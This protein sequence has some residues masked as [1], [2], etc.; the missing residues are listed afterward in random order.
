MAR[1]VPIIQ[2]GEKDTW[3]I[4][5]VLRQLLDLFAFSARE[6]LTA[7]R[8][9]FVAT[10]GNDNSDGL[11]SATAFLTIQ[12]AIDTVAL[13][14]TG[15]SNV[16]VSVAAGTY[17][18]TA[19]IVLK[20]PLG[21][22]TCTLVGDNSNPSNVVVSNATNDCFQASGTRRW[23]IQGIKVTSAAS[24]GVLLTDGAVMVLANMDYG[25][26]AVGAVVLSGTGTS[27]TTLGVNNKW[28]GN[29]P[30]LFAVFNVAS[31]VFN[32]TFTI[33][34][35]LTTTQTIISHGNAYIQI[36]IVWLLG[37]FSVTGRRFLANFDGDIQTFGAG[38]NYIPGSADGQE[39]DG[40]EYR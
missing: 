5:A 34:A 15:I 19:P 8:T 4:V 20:D 24:R 25:A 16:T 32:G 9:Y 6:V 21:A 18:L 33:T 7:S 3:T 26:C 10:T 27:V 12:K 30:N 35:N 17:T 1:P 38:P 13:L 28:S 40:G 2:P 29:T 31:A 11:S 36:S 22:G 39:L 23:N 37:V 14:D